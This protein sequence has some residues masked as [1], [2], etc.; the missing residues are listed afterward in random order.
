[1]S[2]YYITPYGTNHKPLISHRTNAVIEWANC[3]KRDPTYRKSTTLPLPSEVAYYEVTAPTSTA[4]V[5]LV[6]RIL[7][8]KYK[9]KITDPTESLLPEVTI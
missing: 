1:M 2:K 7:N 9:L 3:L 8:S 5:I 4:E 6:Q